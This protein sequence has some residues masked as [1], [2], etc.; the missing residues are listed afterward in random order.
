MAWTVGTQ[1]IG[2]NLSAQYELR[3]IANIKTAIPTPPRK[4]PVLNDSYPGQPYVLQAKPLTTADAQRDATFYATV[5]GDPTL[6][7]D[8][9]LYVIVQD[10]LVERKNVRASNRGVITDMS[11]FTT[12]SFTPQVDT[13]T[14][15]DFIEIEFDYPIDTGLL[16]PS[17]DIDD[18]IVLKQEK[19]YI[20][21]QRTFNAPGTQEWFGFAEWTL[22]NPKKIR[23]TKLLRGL[24]GTD[25]YGLSKIGDI[26]FFYDPSALMLFALTEP[27]LTLKQTIIQAGST[28][29][30]GQQTT[31]FSGL[32]GETAYPWVVHAPPFSFEDNGIYQRFTVFP[33]RRGRANTLLNDTYFYDPY[34]L[35]DTHTCIALVSNTWDRLA[36]IRG[37]LETWSKLNEKNAP[38]PAPIFAV[39]YRSKS[40][41][42]DAIDFYYPADWNDF[43][44]LCGFTPEGRD[45]Y[46]WRGHFGV[47]RIT[48]KLQT[49]YFT[50]TL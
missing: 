20:W 38:L 27:A 45:L 46:S 41:K 35:G 26:C 17:M 32:T 9:L 47:F 48:N 22:I 18:F 1:T 16:L 34:N 30:L 5:L 10:E 21:S 25:V 43:Y 19:N 50:L 4:P 28:S 11:F 44:V 49:E 12:D 23:V 36:S 33:K 42:T 7:V 29:G 14:E 40:F 3:D 39:A 2:V 24:R 8:N 6:V 15:G 37:P 31:T 13:V